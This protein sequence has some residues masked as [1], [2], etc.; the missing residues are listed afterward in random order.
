[1]LLVECTYRCKPGLRPRL[2]EIVKPNIEGS[3][4]EPGNISY[5][6]YPDLY[7]EDAMFVFEKWETRE[8]FEL[9]GKTEHHRTFTALRRPL[10]VPDS[11]QITIYE[12]EVFDDLT[13]AARA[14]AQQNINPQE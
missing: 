5:T 4:K 10:L 2:L 3:R 11:F 8:A 13:R 12:G 6:H 1:M 7:D 14:F 9:H